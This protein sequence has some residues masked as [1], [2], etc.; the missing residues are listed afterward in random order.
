MLILKILDRKNILLSSSIFCLTF[1][2]TIFGVVEIYRFCDL[3]HMWVSFLK[4]HQIIV[5]QYYTPHTVIFW[6][7]ISRTF[8][9]IRGIT[10]NYSVSC[11]SSTSSAATDTWQ[12]KE[13][14]LNFLALQ[15]ASG[16]SSSSGSGVF[17]N[18]KMGPSGP[19][20][21][22]RLLLDSAKIAHETEEIGAKRP[23]IPRRRCRESL[24]HFINT[25]F[26]SSTHTG[27]TEI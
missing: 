22:T 4:L 9:I 16:S 26:C 7:R 11:W 15:M 21:T 12:I 3:S 8:G 17:R 27:I 25:F 13:W 6:N 5:L 2:N 14:D 20:E 10:V 24:R 19:Q 1:N 18:G 23:S